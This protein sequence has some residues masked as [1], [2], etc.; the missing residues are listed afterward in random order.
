MAC[1]HTNQ[2]AESRRDRAPNTS[3]SEAD[4][5]KLQDLELALA[6]AKRELEVFC[7]ETNQTSSLLAVDT[8]PGDCVQEHPVHEYDTDNC[9]Q[10][11]SHP[12]ESDPASEREP[13]NK[14]PPGASCVI[15]RVL[16]DAPQLQTRYMNTTTGGSNDGEGSAA[17]IFVSA[18]VQYRWR[19]CRLSLHEVSHSQ[20]FRTD[21]DISLMIP[22]LY[23]F[24]FWKTRSLSLVLHVKLNR[25][26]DIHVSIGTSGR[27]HG[28]R[29][30]IDRQ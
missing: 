5:R 20:P 3:P 28:G 8:S 13:R 1:S 12:Y 17:V 7:T 14:L 6:K 23:V 19:W 21:T 11:C 25:N 24:P 15:T 10:H 30:P 18:P 22:S 16:S 4:R 29:E 26:V 2:Q 9:C 27:R